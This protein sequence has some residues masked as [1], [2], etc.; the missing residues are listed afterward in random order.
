MPPSAV[1][2]RGSP[3]GRM[4]CGWSRRSSCCWTPTSGRPP[5][6]STGAAPPAARCGGGCPRW[7]WGSARRPGRPRPRP[8]PTL[9]P[10]TTPGRSRPRQPTRG[11]WRC[12]PAT[13][14]PPRTTSWPPTDS[15]TPAKTPAI[16]CTPSG[17]AGGGSSWPAPG[18]P[19]P[20]RTLTDRNREI[21]TEQ[22]WNQSV[23][24]CNRVLAQLAL[25]GA[26]AEEAGVAARRPLRRLREGLRHGQRH[27][28]RLVPRASAPEVGAPRRS[29]P[30]STPGPLQPSSARPCPPTRSGPAVYGRGPQREELQVPLREDP[31]VGSVGHGGAQGRLE[32]ISDLAVVLIDG[33]PVPPSVHLHGGDL[34][35][36]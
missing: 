33:D 36:L 7:G 4:G 25:A 9:P 13:A 35:L 21:S 2:R 10:P 34:Q 16:T 20:A 1:S 28:P 24:R 14:A 29:S 3:A 19:G 30:W 8:P 12:W 26:R 17:A 27:S 6:T 5:T 15:R 11:G 32:R 22:G 31:L 18:R 23:A